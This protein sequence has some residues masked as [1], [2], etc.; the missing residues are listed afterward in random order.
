MYKRQGKGRA[1]G[2]KGA[3]LVS[4]DNGETWQLK[5]G[6]IKSKMWFRDVAFSSPDKGWVVGQ[7]GVVASTND[8]GET[9]QFH[10][11]LSYDMDFFEMPKALECR[12]M[13]TWGPFAR[14]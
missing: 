5:E 14:H 12:G 9:W 6:L 1:I 4:N 3:Y 11:G 8:G 2:D 13:P 7:A 10:S